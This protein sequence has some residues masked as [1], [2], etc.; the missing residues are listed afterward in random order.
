MF[1]KNFIKSVLITVKN[2]KTEKKKL[3]NFGSYKRDSFIV[4]FCIHFSRG[5]FLVHVFGA[6][7]REI[8]I[9]GILISVKECS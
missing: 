8:L 7:K 5:N 3:P 6:Y 2:T 1:K 9:T 4:I